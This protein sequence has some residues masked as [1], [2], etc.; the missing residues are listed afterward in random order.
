[1]PEMTKDLAKIIFKA[2]ALFLMEFNK[3]A[4]FIENDDD[5]YRT[6]YNRSLLS[7]CTETIKDFN[8]DVSIITVVYLLLKDSY[9]DIISW[10]RKTGF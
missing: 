8:Y 2:D 7:A 3:L 10:A 9:Q 5:L 1:M 4:K 6:T